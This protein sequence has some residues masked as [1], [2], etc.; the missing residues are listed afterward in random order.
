MSEKAE[1]MQSVQLGFSEPFE[2]QEHQNLAGH[3]S[4]N[5]LDWDGGQ[6][7]GQPTWLQPRDI[8]NSAVRCKNCS[9]IM[10]FVCQFYAPASEVNESAFHRSFYIFACPNPACLLATCGSVRVLRVQLPRENEFFPQDEQPLWA[11]HLPEAWGVKLC[12][13]CG[14]RSKGKCPVQGVGFCCRDHQKEHKKFVFDK[15]EL[16]G[17]HFLPSVLAASELVVEEEPG[18]NASASDCK[19]EAENTLFE[20]NDET[21]AEDAV[22][23]QQDLNEITGAKNDTTSEDLMTMNFYSRIKDVPNVQDQCLRY[24]RWPQGDAAKTTNSPLWIRS[25]YTPE[26]IPCCAYCG[27]ERQ[28]EFQLMP[29]MLHYLLRNQR[30]GDIKTEETE[31]KEAMQKASSILEQ[32]PKEHLPP[33]FADVKETAAAGFRNQLLSGSNEINWGVV[34]VFTC[35]ASCDGPKADDLGVYKEEFAWKQP[36]LD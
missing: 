30:K 22:L 2:D 15:E 23:E 24:Q 5:W 14:Q 28:F 29:Q 7:G 1:V 12:K 34:A 10:P 25:D 33:A 27:A 35:V 13:V 11:G 16:G 4:A 31:F 6:I 19:T 26:K 18:A 3:T 17:D 8:P 20:N 32:A 36:P 21:D 9:G